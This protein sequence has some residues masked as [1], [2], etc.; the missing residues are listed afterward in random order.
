M[1]GDSNRIQTSTGGHPAMT[2]AWRADGTVS[3]VLPLRDLTI[4][5][6]NTG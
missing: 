2:W 4:I 1:S 6:Y 5:S 3:D